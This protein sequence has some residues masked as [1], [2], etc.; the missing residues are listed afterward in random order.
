[1]QKFAF[2][3]YQLAICQAAIFVLHQIKVSQ[4]IVTDLTAGERMSSGPLQVRGTTIML[5]SLA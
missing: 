5:W 3:S 1:M 2:Q 4:R